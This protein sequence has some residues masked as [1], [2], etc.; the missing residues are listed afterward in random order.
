MAGRATTD[1]G[2]GECPALVRAG[3]TAGHLVA[4]YALGKLYL[5]DDVEVRAPTEGLRW[6]ETAAQTAV[7]TAAYRLG[8]SASR[9]RLP[10]RIPQGLEF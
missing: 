10:R 1:P 7:I 3:G 4:Q 2:L 6:L 5:S 9:E 8:R